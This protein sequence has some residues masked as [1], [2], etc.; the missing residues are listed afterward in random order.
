MDCHVLFC[1]FDTVLINIV[2]NHFIITIISIIIIIVLGP[3]LIQPSTISNGATY[4]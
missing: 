4:R 2:R 3:K 1:K